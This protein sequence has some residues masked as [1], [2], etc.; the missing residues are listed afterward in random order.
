MDVDEAHRAGRP[1]RSRARCAPRR[2]SRLRPRRAATGNR[3]CL[4]GPEPPVGRR[5]LALI[6]E[7][8][9]DR[10]H[11][12][13]EIGGIGLRQRPFI[14]RSR[15]L[16]SQPAA[17]V[18]GIDDRRSPGPKPPRGGRGHRRRAGRR[19]PRHHKARPCHAV[20]A[21]PA[22]CQKGTRAAGPAGHDDRVQAMDIDPPAPGRSSRQA[23]RIHP[24]AGPPP[25]RR[26]SGEIAAA[27]GGD[28]QG[29]P[30]SSSRRL[31]AA[32]TNSTFPARGLGQRR[33]VCV[34]E[35]HETGERVRRL[36]ER[37]ASSAPT[38][39]V[40]DDR[41]SQNAEVRSSVRRTV[42]GH[43]CTGLRSARSHGR[44]DRRRSPTRG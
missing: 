5:H 6:G 38:A 35:H 8:G 12:R 7:G 36:S 42:V 31:A 25:T 44:R 9:G 30:A 23:P 2:W 32:A 28:R 43:A 15:Q 24:P 34:P 18:A 19:R 1:C 41:G 4:R 20:P 27:I 11:A 26:S 40:L 14:C 39:D 29:R 21:R 17:S 33:D 10:L 13:T 22:C 16:R 37:R 3:R